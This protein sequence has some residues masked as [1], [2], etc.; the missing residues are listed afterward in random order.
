MENDILNQLWNN[1]D[2]NPDLVQPETIIQNAK[3]QRKR[4]YIGIVVLTTT[5]LILIVYAVLFFPKS[6]NNFSLGL[7]L[8]I[9]PLVLRIALEVFSIYKKQSKIVEMS[10]KNYHNY[11][12]RF[13]N[14]RKIVNYIITPLFFG[15]YIYGLT[16]LFPYFKREFSE[17]FYTYLVISGVISLILIGFIIIR[18]I[19][20]ENRFYK[21]VLEK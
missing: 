3:S 20:K 19:V 12:K 8:M 14:F 2:H 9:V 13:Y 1:D 15:I 21:E 4:Q 10:S 5:V 18:G 11:L 16:L 17:G 7:L 6:F